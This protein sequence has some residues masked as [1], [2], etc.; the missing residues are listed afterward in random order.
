MRVHRTFLYAGMFLVAVGAV[1]VAADQGLVDTSNLADGLRFWPLAVI[2]VGLGLALRRTR[3]SLSTGMLAAAIPGLVLGGAFAAAPRFA[4]D[5]GARTAPS[6]VATRQGSFDGP[7]SISVTTGCG[8]LAVT[9][10][11]GSAW[12]LDAGSTTGRTPLVAASAQSLSIDSTGAHDWTFPEAGRDSWDLTLPTSE[13]DRLSLVVDAG[14][15]SVALP[16]AQIGRLDLTANAAEVL[17]DAS[18]ASVTNVS[19][20]VNL[21]QLSIHLPAGSDLVGSLRVDAGE[22]DV[23]A[24]PDL[25][26]RV[27]SQVFAGSVAVEGL[28]QAGSTWQ[29]ANYGSAPHRA[30]LDIT[31]NFGAVKINPIGGCR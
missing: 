15:G 14:R 10:A 31:V 1:L 4:V 16:E 12:Q 27:T 21:G 17:V 8:S 11:P 2:A 28:Q 18:A 6:G 30:D 29:S 7:A 26:L 5:C 3:L 25:G 13:I 20:T 9:T 19:A 23:C 22:L 24:P